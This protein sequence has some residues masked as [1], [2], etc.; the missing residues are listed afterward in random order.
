MDE[1]KITHDKFDFWT[2]DYY[3]K[4]FADQGKTQDELIKKV[5]LRNFNLYVMN[6]I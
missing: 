4:K 5:G 2:V 1:P 6:A 3:V